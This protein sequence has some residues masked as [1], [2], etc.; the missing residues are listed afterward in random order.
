MSTNDKL[1]EIKARC[2]ELLEGAEYVPH[3]ATS[4]EAGWRATIAAID[5]LALI[6]EQ[7]AMGEYAGWDAML[8]IITAWE[9][10]CMSDTPSQPRKPTT[11]TATP[12]CDAEGTSLVTIDFARMLER[13]LAVAREALEMIVRVNSNT[14]SENEDDGLPDIHDCTEG[15]FAETEL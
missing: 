6:H 10:D 8:E 5:N 14:D 3:Y 4:A 1:N 2:H 13:K 7:S 12:R 9:G 11:E 15:A